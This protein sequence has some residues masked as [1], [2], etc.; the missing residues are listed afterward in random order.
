MSPG[1]CIH[2]G[3]R[4]TPPVQVCQAC[5]DLL[6]DLGEED[7]P[8]PQP[9]PVV[10]HQGGRFEPTQADIQLTRKCPSAARS[11]RSTKCVPSSCPHHATNKW[12]KAIAS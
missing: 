12:G 11:S 6:S 9:A 1:R 10:T 8:Q 4:V 7:E 3:G 2:C 5:Q